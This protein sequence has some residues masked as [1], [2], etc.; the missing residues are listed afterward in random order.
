MDAA[1]SPFI[2]T[3]K[4]YVRWWWFSERIDPGEI[5]NQVRWVADQ[6]FGGVEIAWVYPLPGA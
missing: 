4:P 1:D 2:R 3:N 6:G 5:A